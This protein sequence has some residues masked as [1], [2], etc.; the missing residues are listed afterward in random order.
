MRTTRFV[1]RPE[2]PKVNSHVREG[3]VEAGKESHERQRCDTNMSRQGSA[4]PSG[5]ISFPV[6][7]PA[8]TGG[9]TY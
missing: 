3:V 5:L 6:Y 8:L 7:F 1:S 2:G 4:G 9:A